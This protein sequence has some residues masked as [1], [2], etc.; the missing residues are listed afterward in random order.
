[1]VPT[2]AI[3]SLE[4]TF[5]DFFFSS[6]TTAWTA[7]SMPRFRS[8]GLAPAATALAPSLTIPCASKVAVVVPSPA[9][10][11]VLEATSRTIWA[12]IFSNLSSSSIS[13][14]TVT[15]SLVTRGA[16]NDLSST[17]L[18][19]FGPSVTLTA[20]V[21]MSTPR[22]MR[23]RASCENFTSFA[24]IVL[25]HQFLLAIALGGLFLASGSAFE[26]AHDVA[27]LHD[28]E[29]FAVDLDLGARPFAEQHPVTSLHVERLNHS[30]V[31]SGTRSHRDDFPLLWLLLGCIGND[32]AAG[33]ALVL[34]DT[35]YD[36][37][38]V[39]RAKLHS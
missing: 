37:S 25:L 17:T 20:L 4:V 10:S 30:L 35:A 31:V 21:K 24:A 14:A 12:P 9:V 1:M 2:C 7:R 26:N 29:I 23:S 27:L 5:L 3:S 18:R 39:Q 33:R 22:S 6:S 28:E 19:P 8:I 13:L 34:L 36:D 16:P 15:P 38:V 32:D 11:E